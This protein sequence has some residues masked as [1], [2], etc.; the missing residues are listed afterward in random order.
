MKIRYIILIIIL[1][2][3][4]LG[5]S[6][7]LSQGPKPYKI[8]Y[9]V[10]GN[11]QQAVVKSNHEIFFYTG[12]L[13]AVYDTN[14]QTTQ[15]LSKAHSLPTIGSISWSDTGVVFKASSYSGGDELLPI[16]ESQK[17]DPSKEYWWQLDFAT[18]VINILQNSD[19]SIKTTNAI[20]GSDGSIITTESS[21]GSSV[22]TVNIVTKNERKKIADVNKGSNLLSKTDNTLYING[23]D[24][25]SSTRA[26]ISVDINNGLQK[27]LADKVVMNLTAV[28]RDDTQIAFIQYSS[29]DEAK[30]NIDEAT[31]FSSG[32][33]SYISLKNGAKHQ[34]S[35]DFNGPFNWVEDNLVYGNNINKNIVISETNKKNE[36]SI[37]NPNQYSVSLIMPISDGYL[38]NDEKSNLY[39]ASR[40]QK[41]NYVPSQDNS[42]ITKLRYDK[43]VY[44]V[45]YQ[46]KE[47]RYD[48]IIF[49]NPFHSQIDAFN[50]VLIKSGLDPNQAFINWIPN[51]NVDPSS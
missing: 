5:L 45:N 1:V 37:L 40:S 20:I 31:D 6:L 12:S 27:V 26:I 15:A 49:K 2:G 17:L 38:L 44:S 39:L 3:V 33:L 18:N 16:L 10:A 47:N 48:V 13:F 22:E 8:S 21:Q 51:D 19:A 30:N 36:A 23:Y 25:I 4:V 35:K 41:T 29:P 34:V 24:P 9:P 50:K 14:N 11:L 42:L 32:V 7:W 28:S 46:P 43:S